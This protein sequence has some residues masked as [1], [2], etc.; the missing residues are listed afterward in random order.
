MGVATVGAGLLTKPR[1]DGRGGGG[2]R[3]MS[4]GCGVA[5]VVVSR[6][7]L[8]GVFHGVLGRAALAAGWSGLECHG[9]VAV[10]VEQRG[11][12][13]LPGPHLREVE[14]NPSCRARDPGGDGDSLQRIIAVVAFARSGSATKLA[15]RVRLNAITASTTHAECATNELDG[16]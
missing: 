9:R 11:P 8:S 13:G 1:S 15:Q 4:L 2:M 12:G 7:S 6:T 10:P 14:D 5:G 16:R 3:W